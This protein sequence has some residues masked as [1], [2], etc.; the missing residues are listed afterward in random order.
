MQAPCQPLVF[1][2]TD[3][4][5]TDLARQAP[6]LSKAGYS[7]FVM[8]DVLVIDNPPVQDAQMLHVCIAAGLVKKRLFT[9]RQ[10]KKFRGYHIECM[11]ESSVGADFAGRNAVGRFA[12]GL[13]DWP[14][15]SRLQ[16]ALAGLVA[17]AGTAA[18]Q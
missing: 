14:A 9:S 7:R 15:Q 16:N 8:N 1:A 17:S 12:V 10:I 6:R 18:C 4:L 13:V 3:D 5:K 11:A 2:G